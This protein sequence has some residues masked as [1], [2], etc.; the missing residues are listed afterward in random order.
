MKV[1]D[2]FVRLRWSLWVVW[3]LK[4]WLNP[5]MK[6]FTLLLVISVPFNRNCDEQ[7]GECG[8]VPSIFIF[9]PLPVIVRSIS[10]IFFAVQLVSFL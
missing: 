8:Y 7:D 9:K 5:K 2:F 1:D 3:P 10:A 4:F 6:M